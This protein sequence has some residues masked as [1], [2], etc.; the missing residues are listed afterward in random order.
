M[1]SFLFWAHQAEVD[2]AIRA[3]GQVIASGRSQIIQATDGGVLVQLAV[4]EGQAVVKGQSLAVLDRTRS[5]AAYLESQA[6]SVALMGQVARLRSELSGQPLSFPFE[7]NAYPV[8]KRE[9]T[10]LFQKRRFSIAQELEALGRV[11]TLARR[12]LELNEPLLKTGDISEVEIIR[13]KRQLMDV[14][15][16]I[17]SKRNKYIQDA[18]SELTKA[19]EELASARQL[20]AQRKDSLLRTELV[21]PV[22]G[23]VK[24]VRITTIGAVVRPSEE[25]LQIVPSKDALVVEVRVRPQD[26]GRLKP[27]LSANIKIDAYDYTVYGSLKGTLTYLSPD[28]LSEDIKANEQP[29]YR[30]Q[31]QVSGQQF[32]ARPN[33]PIDIQP[34]MTAV[35]EVTTG[36]HT[37]LNYLIKPVIKTFSESLQER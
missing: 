2:Q 37:V 23:V 31:I 14:E 7:L 35:A 27:G 19:E 24:N 13:L 17:S 22:D 5:E 4:K 12:E 25:V 29:Y 36:S 30:A 26:V 21:A 3:S 20:S 1:A 10:E 8:F 32:S 34:G 11:E 18:Q 6:K 33:E 9:Q 28:T 15:F 16:Q